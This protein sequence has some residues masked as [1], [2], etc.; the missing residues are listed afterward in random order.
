[1]GNNLEKNENKYNRHREEMTQ[2]REVLCFVF[3]SMLNDKYYFCYEWTYLFY[4]FI[5]FQVGAD[6]KQL[7]KPKFVWLVVVSV[8]S[9]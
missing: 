7:S 9:D 8:N 4:H 5:A 2:H 1:M 3:H 6:W